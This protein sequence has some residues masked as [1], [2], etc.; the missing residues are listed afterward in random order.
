MFNVCPKCG[1]YTPEK[2]IRGEIAVCPHC[3]GEI[4]FRKLP[5]FLV[6]GPC[7]VGKST[8]SGLLS[9]MTDRVVVLENDILWE[10]RWNTPENN[11]RPFRELWLRMC[12]NISQAGK[13][14][15]LAGCCDPGQFEPCVER[16]YFSELHYL[17]LVAEPEML[18]ARLRGRPE[19]RQTHSDEFIAGQLAYN[20]WFF[21]H[22]GDTD[23][24][25]ELLDTTGLTPE[26]TAERVLRWIEE[27]M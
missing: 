27:R 23:P 10:Q 22:H 24:P 3:G 26:E 21:D 12:K 15:L 7:G 5:L 25:I 16:R 14:C 9:A 6:S 13:P 8:V 20:Q 18:A 19:W 2:E 4:A 11:Y 17:A 1:M